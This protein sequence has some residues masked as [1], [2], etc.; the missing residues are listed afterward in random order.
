M[1]LDIIVTVIVIATMVQGYRHG[2]LKSF[3]HVVGWFAA[4]AAAFICSPQVNG[5]LLDN[6]NIINLIYNKINEK[7]STAL[8]PAD[9]QESMPTI[10]QDPLTNLTNSLSGSIS[11]SLSNLLFTIACFLIIVLA[12]RII[13][14]ILMSFLSKEHNDGIT[15]FADGLMGMFF[16]FIKGILYVFVFLAFMI[17]AASL[18]NPEIM[19]FLMGSLES[20]YIAGDLYNNNLILLIMKNFL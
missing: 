9:M 5:F 19:N 8:S 2:L 18:A 12:V 11:L 3:I 1:I 6:T 4:L 17:P 15:G 7:V 14:H 20:S 13:L 16:G 10:I